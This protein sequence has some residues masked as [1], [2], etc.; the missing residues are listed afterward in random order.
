MATTPEKPA[1][2]SPA[3]AEPPKKLEP[4]ILFITVCGKR[5]WSRDEGRLPPG[6]VAR[7]TSEALRELGHGQR[8]AGQDYAG[9][10]D[11][12]KDPEKR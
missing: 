9:P 11:A 8:G 2:A 3:E 7:R 4:G 12:P 6:E 10:P 1:A 5:V